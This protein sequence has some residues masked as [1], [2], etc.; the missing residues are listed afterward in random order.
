MIDEE[1]V[2][3]LALRLN[4]TVSYT[5]DIYELKLVIPPGELYTPLERMFLPLQAEVWIAI[6]VTLLIGLGTILVINFCPLKVRNFVFGQDIRTPTI[7]LAAQFLAGGQY[8]IPMRNFARF[9]LMLFIIKKNFT[10][11]CD[12]LLK[13]QYGWMTEDRGLPA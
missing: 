1:Q 9:L 6:V 5:I 13:V 10:F 8:K 3:Y 2:D 12:N 7:N 11:L 4:I